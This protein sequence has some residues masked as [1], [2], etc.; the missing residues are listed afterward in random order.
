MAEPTIGWLKVLRL[1]R[2][3]RLGVIIDAWTTLAAIVIC[4]RILYNNTYK[5][6]RILSRFLFWRDCTLKTRLHT[7]L[8]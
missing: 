1:L 4:F 3:D 5:K 8:C 6:P 2:Y 7:G